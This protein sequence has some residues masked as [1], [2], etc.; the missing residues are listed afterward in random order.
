MAQDR[1]EPR[2]LRGQSWGWSPPPTPGGP[3]SPKLGSCTLRL[4]TRWCDPC[5]LTRHLGTWHSAGGTCSCYLGLRSP[6][7]VG[8]GAPWGQLL[9][10]AQ[11]GN[12]APELVRA[13]SASWELAPGANRGL[14]VTAELPLFTAALGPGSQGPGTGVQT[15]PRAHGDLSPP[16]LQSSVGW[17]GCKLSSAPLW[18]V[19]GRGSFHPG[20]DPT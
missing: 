10:P 14:P 8:V 20:P 5:Q 1:L 4:C 6:P 2:P 11:S 16:P 17:G 3:V 12:P 13:L 15:A 19:V 18:L 9:T 7:A